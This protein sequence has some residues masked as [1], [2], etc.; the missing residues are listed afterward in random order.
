M[1]NIIREDVVQVSFDVDLQEIN[2]LQ[3]ELNNLKKSVSGGI[4]DDA[5][6]DLKDGA[7]KAGDAMEDTKEDADKLNNKLKDLGN[8][9]ASAAYN[10]LKKVAGI[11]FKALLA[12]VAATATGVGVIA[13]QALDAYADYEQLKGGVETLFGAKGAKSVEEYAKYTGKSVDAVKKEYDTL[14]KAQEAVLKNADNAWWTAGLSANDYMSTVTTFS[15]SL[16]KS[17]DGDT[18]KAAEL[19]DM[20][21][22]DMA[23]NAN[24]MGTDI[25]M[26]QSAYSGIARGNYMMLDNLKLGYAGSK[27]ELERLLSDAEKIK[28]EMGET[29]DYDVSSYADVIEAI[30]TIQ[31]NMGITGTT[32]KEAAETVTGSLNAMKASWQN[33]LIAMGSGEK[34]DECME[35]MLK[36][37]ETFADNAI[38]VVEKALVGMGTLVERVTPMIEEKLPDL[39][40]KLLPPLIKAAV[41][42]VKGLI[43]A[44]PNIIKTLATTIVDIFGEQFP[45]IKKIGD[46]FANNADK[47]ATFIPVL[48]GIAMAFSAFGNIKSISNVFSGLFGKGGT[49]EKSG[50]LFGGIANLAKM[51]TTEVLKGMANLAIILG[52]LTLLTAVLMK[53][54][55]AMAE[56]SDAKSLV[57][58]IAFITI[59]GA[60]ATVLAR[61]AEIVGKIPIMTVL[62]GLANMAIIVAGMSALLLLIGAVSLINFDYKK[63]LALVG[64]LGV[65]GT[66]GAALTVFAGIVGVIPIPVVLAGLANMALVLGGLTAIVLAFG[67]LS[68]IEGID[69]LVNTGGDLLADLFGVLGKIVGSIIGNLGEAMSEHL[70]AIGENLAQFGTNIKPLFTVMSGVDMGGVGAFFGALALLFGSAVGNDIWSGIKSLF[71]D[72][73]SGFAKLGTD[74][75]DFGINAKPFFV[76]VAKYP[77]NS[78]TNATKMFECLAGLS[79][80]PNSGGV[81]GWFCGEVDYSKIAN[82]LDSLSGEGIK[83]FFVMVGELSPESFEN[84][85]LFFESLDGLGGLPNS[86]GVAGWFAGE[87]KYQNIANGLSALG[88]DGVKKFF[89]MAGELTPQAFENTKHLFESLSGMSDSL[90]KEDNWWDKLWGNESVSLGDIG[91]DLGAFAK[92]STSFF[93]TV[94]SLNLGNLNGMW[95]SLKNANGLTADISK[96]IDNNID[97]IVAKISKLPNKM[98]NALKGG[99]K[100][101]GDSFVEVWKEA[102]KASVSPVNKLLSGANHI[103]KEFGSK[104]K[105]IEW[106]PYARGTN[107][108][109]GGNALVNDGN[110]AEL[111]QMPNGHTFIPNGRNVMIPNAPK[112]MKVLPANQTARLLGKSS[113]T[114]KYANGIGNIDIWGYYD[115]AEG[116]VKAITKNISY[117]GMSGFSSSL[118]K[119]MVSTFAGEM[120]A[121]IDKLFEECGQSI[122]SYVASKGVTQWL[123][124]VVRALKMEGQYSLFNVA[125]TL[126][127]MKTESGGN[128]MAINLWD[129]NAKNGTPSKGLMQVIDPTFRAYARSGFDKNIY[130]PLSNVLASIRYATSRYGSLGN[131]FRGVGY[132]DGVGTV[133]LP[134]RPVNL[135]YTPESDAEYSSRYSIENNNYSP[136][137][138]INVSGSSDDRTLARKVK[139]A[140]KEAIDEMLDE[141]DRNNPSLIEV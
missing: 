86:G 74:L 78:F 52:G 46:F 96:K 105:L 63:M 99:G 133:S 15:A 124:T 17:L 11:T 28:K 14:T 1:A 141:T 79:N 91:A 6:D 82:G 92:N 69:E 116:L 68:Q 36:S 65:L 29:V 55:P 54:A 73:E 129:K 49:G 51:K 95:E 137:F 34:L 126:F 108:H 18:T 125:R 7:K 10:G 57:E 109:K 107:G 128:P 61:F 19:S 123:P 97:D 25:S 80:L 72:N 101:L 113:P 70:P 22:K 38:P 122:S 64:I 84:A 90:P 45:I 26:I 5:F 140:V 42:L 60:V 127:Q 103:L 139:K 76:A 31:E 9:G 27:T 119:G 102:V 35:N 16:I 37:A 138:I 39:A 131:A 2:N 67:E 4:G 100:A 85:K 21:L 59:L 62:K 32:E 13:K 118:G 136:Q 71:G 30:H 93:K 110:G 43:K 23:D 58:V 94:N 87:I 66:V 134:S 112:G 50:G 121:W 106:Q 3:K 132:S 8:K 88:G 40:D 115:N 104:K 120:P 83:K 48:A 75:A 114:F 20:A 24:K 44:L 41:S 117:T 12:G 135:S 33:L 98:G 77:E 89:T 56:L 53:I 81:V 47:I 111:V 130:D